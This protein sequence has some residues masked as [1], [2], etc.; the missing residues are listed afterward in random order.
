MKRLLFCLLFV[1]VSF[2]NA[3]DNKTS[4]VK[5]AVETFF[6]G[7]HLGD[8]LVMKSVMMP[9][10]S[11][12]TAYI[13]GKGEGVFVDS[14]GPDKLLKAIA[15]RPADQKWDERLTN[16]DIKVFLY[17]GFFSAYSTKSSCPSSFMNSSMYPSS[18]K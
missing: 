15:N 17:K 12:Q 8:T 18:L 7:F 10:M 11:V 2:V 5:A 14:G 4:E 1:C 9:K 3:Q 13:N 16:F 6:K